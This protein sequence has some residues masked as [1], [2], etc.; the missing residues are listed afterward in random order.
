MTAK[1]IFGGRQ[2]DG[3]ERGFWVPLDKSEHY[4]KT[5][6]FLAV[7]FHRVMARVGGGPK[8]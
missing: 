1:H 7:F 4:V 5:Q 6:N 3:W 2:L 8:F